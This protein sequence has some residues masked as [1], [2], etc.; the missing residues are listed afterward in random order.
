[1]VSVMI[2]VALVAWDF[3]LMWILYYFQYYFQ[4]NIW[5]SNGTQKI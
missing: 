2:F 1:M 3:I 4:S 5:L